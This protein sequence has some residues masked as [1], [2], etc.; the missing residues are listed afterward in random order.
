[1]KTPLPCSREA[2][3][4]R[5]EVALWGCRDV[6]GVYA[7]AHEGE[8]AAEDAVPGARGLGRARASEADSVQKCSIHSR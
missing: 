1:M 7:V 3:G 4:A 8:D 2:C 6:Q 5:A